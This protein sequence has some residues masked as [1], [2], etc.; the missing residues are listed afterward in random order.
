MPS[1]VTLSVFAFP[2]PAQGNE[3]MLL[4]QNNP[5]PGTPA[6]QQL[7]GVSPCWLPSTLQTGHTWKVFSAVKYI[8]NLGLSGV[9]FYLSSVSTFSPLTVPPNGWCSGAGETQ[10]SA[11]KSGVRL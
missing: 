4:S 10:G 8:Y 6:A 5:S 11:F 2:F 7:L 3:A 9:L 1:G